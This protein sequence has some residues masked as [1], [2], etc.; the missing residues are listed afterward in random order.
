MPDKDQYTLREMR[1]GNRRE[2]ELLADMWNR[3]DAG[4]PGGWTGGVPITADR[5]LSEEMQWDCYGQ[6]VV[7]HGG[8]IVG[9]V[10]MMADPSQPQR[11]YLGMLN[12]RPDHHGR[13][14]GKRLVRRCVDCATEAGLA[15]LDLYTWAGNLKAVPL[16]KK[17]GF[18]W[19]PETSVEMQNFIPTIVRT[20]LL[21]DFFGKHDWYEV[22][23]RDLAVAEDVDHWRG[24]RVY[25][26]RFAAEG[27]T[28]EVVADR[29][30][31][32][33]TAVETNE[34]SV[35]A[36]V[37]KEDLSALQE[38]TLRY[39]LRNKTDRSLQVSIIAQGEPGVPVSLEESFELRGRR[40][41]TVPF[42]LPADLERK[43]P[44]EPAHRILTTVTVDGVPVK[45]GTAVRMRDPV[46][47]ESA[48]WAFAAGKWSEI[49]IKLRNRLPFPVSGS[50]WLGAP[51][52]L[53]R[54]KGQL[55]FRI[56]RG[57]WTRVSLRL[58]ASRPGAF[59][60]EARV[61]F[62]RETAQRLAKG[63]TPAL[64]PRGRVRTLW[65]RAFAPGTFAVSNDAETHRLTVESDRMRVMFDR[66][67][68]YLAVWHRAVGRGLMQVWMPEAGPP[69]GQFSP[70]PP[71]YDV[72]VRERAGAVDLTIRRPM[73]RHPGLTL[74]RTVV[75]TAEMLELRHRLVNA[76]D[77]RA[78]VKVKAG[79]HGSLGGQKITVPGAQGLIQHDRR[80]GDRWPGWREIAGRSS[81]FSETWIAAEE[82]GAVAGVVWDGDAEVSP[83]GGGGAELT[84]GPVA[85]PAGGAS[86]LPTIR[87]IVGPGD[88][89]TVRSAWETYVR[90]EPLLTPAERNP[91]IRKLLRGGLSDVPLLLKRS[92]QRTALELATEQR[93]KLTA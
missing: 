23:E 17:M 54:S 67:G 91:E 4:W 44:G 38:H 73:E 59:P 81:E 78:E 58:R 82:E 22:Q 70:V 92:P 29:W 86:D 69:F 33:L 55:T 62:S 3:S 74:E 10:S 76:T 6:W 85:V 11:G 64:A 18:F 49:H 13:G 65:V 79:L 14:V 40:R 57:G 53:E 90:A 30:A 5:V 80:N 48:D 75:V 68:G 21:A 27:Q 88:Y 7:E 72:E 34:V 56:A 84:F 37:G 32:M 41:L 51:A 63:K 35:A 31:R 36:W 60:V 1:I 28:I 20:P 8:E 24:V 77:R 61:N 26:Y 12:A 89:K 46:E 50:L 16:Y 66:S 71:V 45:L 15:E 2:A 9:L 52:E 39:E 83:S 93:R 87:A 43:K 42:R 25:R 19:A 47:I